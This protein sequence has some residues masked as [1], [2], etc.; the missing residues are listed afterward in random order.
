VFREFLDYC[1]NVREN[2]FSKMGNKELGHKW[3]HRLIPLNGSKYVKIIS[4][5]VLMD[6][7]SVP[8]DSDFSSKSAWAFV[9]KENGDIYKP[10]TYSAPAKHARGNIFDKNTWKT[11][12]AFGPAYMR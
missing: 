8:K 3:F 2:Y 1:N 5:S 7:D 11:I 6:K 12:S 10:A 9:D 4:S